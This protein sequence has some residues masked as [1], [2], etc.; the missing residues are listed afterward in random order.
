MERGLKNPDSPMRIRIVFK[1][2]TFIGLTTN[3]IE[4]C[5]L[6]GVEK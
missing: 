2:N 1:M 4:K 6:P 3:K 5:F